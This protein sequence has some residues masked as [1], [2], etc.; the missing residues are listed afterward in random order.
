[1]SLLE[2]AIVRGKLGLPV[3]RDLHFEADKPVSAYADEAHTR[4]HRHLTRPSAAGLRV[5]GLRQALQPSCHILSGLPSRPG[6]ISAQFSAS[7]IA[8]TRAAAELRYFGEVQTGLWDG[9]A[10]PCEC[11]YLSSYKEIRKGKPLLELVLPESP[12]MALR[13][14]LR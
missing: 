5:G 9:A 8:S 1:V 4:S 3:E 14:L 12:R 13:V 11:G 2:L 7:H 10:I 6:R